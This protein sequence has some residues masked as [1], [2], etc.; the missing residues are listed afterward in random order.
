MYNNQQ[1]FPFEIC[2]NLNR[3][4]EWKSTYQ[5]TQNAYVKHGMSSLI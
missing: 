5:S 2:Q 4:V 3:F 1:L